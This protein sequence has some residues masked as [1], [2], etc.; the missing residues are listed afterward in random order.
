MTSWQTAV[1]TASSKYPKGETALKFGTAGFR[2]HASLLV[3]P[4]F[5][6]GL[7]AAVRSRSVGGQVIGVMITASHNPVQDN[8]VKLV[9]PMGE[10]FPGRWEQFA[11]DLVNADDVVGAL[12]AIIAAEGVDMSTPAAVTFAVDTRPSGAEL[13]AALMAG[14]AA[15]GATPFDYG[16]LTTPQLH[17]MVRCKNTQLR[18]GADNEGGYFNKLADAYYRFVGGAKGAPSTVVVDAANGVG[19]AKARQLAL[20]LEDVL[21]IKVVNDGTGGG[22]LNLDCG[23]DHVKTGQKQPANVT[24]GGSGEFCSLDGDADRI[25]Y[26]FADAAGTFRL[27]DGDRIAAL[28]ARFIQTALRTV[29]LDLALGVVQTAYANGNSTRFMR[30]ELGAEVVFACTGVKHLHHKAEAF[31]IGVYFE[32][33]GHGTVVFS[34][35]AIDALHTLDSSAFSAEQLTALRRLRALPDLINQTVGDALSDM[36]LVQGILAVTGWTCADWLAM[37]SDLANRLL[38]VTVADRGVFETADADTRLVQPAGLHEQVQALVAP[39]ASGRSFVRPSGTEDVVRV[40]AEADTQEATDA[41]G[42]AVAKLVHAKA[43]GVGPEPSL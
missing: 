17:Y 31:D 1:Q 11:T 10:M 37:Y 9:D 26:Y 42:I 25:V 29:G 35:K 28:A 24:L 18:F 36:L 20:A 30:E 2:C 33:N 6:V 15:V 21:T 22:V 8:G 16:Q 32:A 40:Y 19:A 27:L 3:S 34:Q 12:E 41:L 38:K 39:V 14:L 23:A 5:R 4:S 13:S 43:G 7:L